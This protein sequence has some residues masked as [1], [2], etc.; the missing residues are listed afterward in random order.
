MLSSHLSIVDT[1]RTNT[2]KPSYITEQHRLM[3]EKFSAVRTKQNGDIYH[4]MM[5]I[6]DKKLE[7]TNDV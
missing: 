5:C 2:K 3:D 4:F 6:Q 7:M 1:M